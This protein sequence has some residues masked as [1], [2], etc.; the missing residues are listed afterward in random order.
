MPCGVT[1]MF[2]SFSIHSSSVR[3]SKSGSRLSMRMIEFDPFPDT[4]MTPGSARLA[5]TLW[6][7]PRGGAPFESSRC[8]PRFSS[9]SM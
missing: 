2:S 4:Q 1:L 5:K 9:Y 8:G 6:M 3:V 7:L